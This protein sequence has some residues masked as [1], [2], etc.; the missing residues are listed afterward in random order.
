MKERDCK[1]TLSLG[2]LH[3]VFEHICT[4]WFAPARNLI[5]APPCSQNI[6]AAPAP[7]RFVPALAPGSR[8]MLKQKQGHKLVGV[9]GPAAAPK[10][11][12]K[13]MKAAAVPKGGGRLAGDVAGAAAGMSAASLLQQPAGAAAAGT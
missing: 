7:A 8:P 13:Q 12:S 2:W 6:G 9:R 1:P 4:D 10:P 11:A 3:L 5:L